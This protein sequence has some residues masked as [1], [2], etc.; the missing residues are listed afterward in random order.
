VQ[1]FA[2]QFTNKLDAKGR[3]SVPSEFRDV[4]AERKGGGF[5]C[6]ISPL[7]AALS[8]YG[9]DLFEHYEERL[10]PY[11]PFSPEYAALAS[12]VYSSCR[13]LVFDPEGRVR[14]PDDFIAHAGIQE[15]ALFCG[16]GSFFEIWNPEAY[17]PV[18]ARRRADAKAALTRKVVS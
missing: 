11:D 17:E 10:K 16:M 1:R 4:L 2:G 15:R 7:E 8:G 18:Q 3:V 9:Q 6:T 14:L 13:Y 12:T 5:H